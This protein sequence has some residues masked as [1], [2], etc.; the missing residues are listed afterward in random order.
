M[1]E[2]PQKEVYQ[3][4]YNAVFRLSENPG[5]E[6]PECPERMPANLL[7][8]HSPNCVHMNTRWGPDNVAAW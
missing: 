6:T 7:L 4:K 2:M 3:L 8:P 1:E 5:K